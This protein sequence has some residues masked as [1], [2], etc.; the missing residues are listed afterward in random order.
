M[1]TLYRT[2]LAG[3]LGLVP[4][5][6]HA[7]VLHVGSG[8]SINAAISQMHGGDTLVVHAG[9][10]REALGPLPSGSASQPTTLMAA[11]GELVRI[12]PPGDLHSIGAGLIS[13]EGNDL[14]ISGFHV[15]AQSRWGACMRV[16]GANNSYC[17]MEFTGAVSQC[18][19]GPVV[20]SQFVDIEVHHTGIYCPDIWPSDPY[21]PY[22]GYHHGLYLQAGGDNILLDHV[23]VHDIPDGHGVQAYSANV[24]VH[25]SSI[26][27]ITCDGCHG[28]W[29]L[30]GGGTLVNTTAEVAGHYDTTDAGVA[31]RHACPEGGGLPP[32]TRR[33]PPPHHLRLVVR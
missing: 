30:S 18:I 28:I 4:L 31:V 7:A 10:Y 16:D 13:G 21:C 17:H 3:C 20:D 32:P 1:Q 5:G 25:N 27:S 8:Q 23:R 33:R 9:T 15:D 19:N 2:L 29:F 11:P 6:A 22:K 24:K 26:T 12:E 14:V